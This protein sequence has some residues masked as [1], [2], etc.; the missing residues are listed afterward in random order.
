MKT[1]DIKLANGQYLDFTELPFEKN[2]YCLI[3]AGTGMGKTTVVMEQLPNHF[4]LVLFLL[5]STVKVSELE[6]DYN[7]TKKIKLLS[8]YFFTTTI[9]RKRMTLKSLKVSLYA[10]MI[11]STK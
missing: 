6:M 3:T 11:S 8:T 9:S 4:D 2:Q 1:Q 10:R 5:P 7:K